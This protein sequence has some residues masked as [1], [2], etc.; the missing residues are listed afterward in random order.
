MCRKTQSVLDNGSIHQDFS[1]FYNRWFTVNRYQPNVSPSNSRA[2]HSHITTPFF[3]SDPGFLLLPRH[4]SE[5]EFTVG[6]HE[7]LTR[8]LS[9]K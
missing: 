5:T 2:S 1:H 3:I 4:L 8:D 6:G 7:P 9:D